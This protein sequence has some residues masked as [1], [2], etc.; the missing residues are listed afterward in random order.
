[1]SAEPPFGSHGREKGR[2][3]RFVT[4]EGGE[5]AGKSTQMRL[6]QETLA[7]RGVEAIATR[8]PGGSPH[9]E[10]L[11]EALLGGRAAP[12]GPL[13]EAILFSAARIDH[14]DRLIKPALARGAWV[15]CDR[16]A[17]ST[18]AYQ[19]ARGGVD[20]RLIALLE[21]VA[22]L[23]A[24]PDL[25]IILDIP[26]EEGLERAKRRRRPDEPPDRFESEGLAFHEGLRRAYLDIA[27]SEP[28]RCCVVDARAPEQEVAQAIWHIV[29]AR[30]FRPEAA[31]A[32]ASA[33]A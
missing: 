11:R 18:R 15:I 28:G 8:E 22:L 1:M 23:G 5:G 13:G 24:K 25:T 26:P 9:A 7:E 16:F 33:T 3:G 30:F 20:P 21:R 27:A 14:L 6:L 2:P 17:D 32:A 4:L 19:G 10:A 12:L 29:E 31:L